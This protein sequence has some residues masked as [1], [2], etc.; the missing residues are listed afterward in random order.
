MRVLTI[1]EAALM[2]DGETVPCVSGR[3]TA[4]YPR[5][6][7]SNL[8]GDWS[9]QNLVL[10]DEGAEIKLKIKDRPPIEQSM[11]G[12]FVFIHCSKSEKQGLV[13]VK[14]KDDEY[15]GK[16]EKLLWITGAAHITENA[17]EGVAQPDLPASREQPYDAHKQT[18]PQPDPVRQCRAEAMRLANGYG[19]AL[20]A[21]AYVA[22]TWNAEH[23]SESCITDEHFRSIT[24]TLFIALDRSGALACLPSH[25]IKR[26]AAETVAAAEPEED[27]PF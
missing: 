24:A 13:G 10:K 22:E 8:K 18:D 6:A 26:P 1:A 15:Q 4:V 27:C 19:I 20:W 16:T 11:K 7:G 9:F 23:D 25:P 21:A 5:K 3:I 14:R 2:D 17:P 12:R